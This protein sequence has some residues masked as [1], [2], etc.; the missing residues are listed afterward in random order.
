MQS[1]K[2]KQNRQVTPNCQSQK[3]SENYCRVYII[4]KI[5]EWLPITCWHNPKR[6]AIKSHL[7]DWNFCRKRK[8]HFISNYRQVAKKKQKWETALLV[9]SVSVPVVVFPLKSPD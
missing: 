6:Q 9:E 8:D 1:A 3:F 7:S 2:R 4:F 5:N